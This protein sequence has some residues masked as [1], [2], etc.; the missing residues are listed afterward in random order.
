MER[1]NEAPLAELADGEECFSGRLNYAPVKGK[2]RRLSRRAK[3]LIGLAALVGTN[4]AVCRAILPE[5]V[6]DCTMAWSY[7]YS[8]MGGMLNNR[9]SFKFGN[10]VI[11]GVVKESKDGSKDLCFLEGYSGLNGREAVDYHKLINLT[12]PNK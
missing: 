6:E 4:N 9:I 3:V 12:G 1:E 11:G 2:R 5:A 8:Y 10:R 7:R